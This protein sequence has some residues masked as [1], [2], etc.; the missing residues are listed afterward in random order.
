MPQVE[1]VPGPLDLYVKL[2]KP[3]RKKLE[4]I[5]E[6]LKQAEAKDDAVALR[7]AIRDLEI[8]LQPDDLFPRM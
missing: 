1:D 6:A 3:A 8:A 4:R 5:L 2:T 7:A